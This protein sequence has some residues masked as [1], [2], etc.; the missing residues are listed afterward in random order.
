MKQPLIICDFDGTITTND[1]I[2]SIMKQFAPEEWLAL[3]D[4][5]LSRD[6]SIKDGVGKMFQLLPTSL[7]ED[8]MGYVLKQAE[9]RPGFT[10]FVSFLDEQ[11]LPFYVVSGGM[12]FF[13]YPLLEG[14]VEKERIYCNEADFSGRNIEIRWP[15]PCDGSCGNECGCCKP[16]II[17]RLKGRDDFV[18]MIGD[19]VTDV[20]AAKCSDL[21]IARDYLLRECEGLGL[22]HAGFGDFRDVKRILEETAEVKEWTLSKN[23]K[24]LPR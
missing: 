13:V 7:K 21:C 8:I 4:G 11:G 18:V 12:D 24:N 16:S 3:K 10:E 5:V 20:E 15:Y 6:I 9:I 22:K 2:I 14:I 23:G 19:S 17:R 1:N